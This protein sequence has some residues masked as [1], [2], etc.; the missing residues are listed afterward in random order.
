MNMSAIE[1]TTF[2]IAGVPRIHTYK[3]TYTPS[4]VHLKYTYTTFHY[5][6]LHY[7]TFA[8]HYITFHGITL[9][10]IPSH[11]MPCHAMPCRAACMCM[12]T[13]THIHIY[14][15]IIYINTYTLFV[16]TSKHVLLLDIASLGLK[17]TPFRAQLRA[18]DVDPFGQFAWLEQHLK[19]VTAEG[20]QAWGGQREGAVL[21]GQLLVCLGVV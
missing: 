20:G 5:T 21:R 2:S 15:Y 8:L 13:N 7:I 16:C 19:R 4:N 10:Y 17:G 11:S 3:Y 6:T 14:I 1:P 18:Q 12:S 9:H